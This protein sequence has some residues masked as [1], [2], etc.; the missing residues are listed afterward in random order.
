[1]RA[2]VAMMRTTRADPWAEERAGEHRPQE[3]GIRAAEQV[4]WQRLHTVATATSDPTAY[5]AALHAWRTARYNLDRAHVPVPSRAPYV[6]ARSHTTAPLSGA[7]GRR[8]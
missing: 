1:V 2:M 8:G 3:W 6:G 5:R 7:R 4:A